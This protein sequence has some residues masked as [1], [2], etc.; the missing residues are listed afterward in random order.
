MEDIKKIRLRKYYV[1]FILGEN[2]DL[3]LEEREGILKIFIKNMEKESVREYNL[4]SYSDLNKVKD[5]N[6]LE[7]IFRYICG[8]R[9]LDINVMLS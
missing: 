6:V 5:I 2:N 7:A 4:G 9:G 8:K 1:D 3:S